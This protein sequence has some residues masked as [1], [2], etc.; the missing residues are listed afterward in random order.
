MSDWVPWYIETFEIE[1]WRSEPT[2][3]TITFYSDVWLSPV[4]YR[5]ARNGMLK[6]WGFSN[7]NNFLLGS[8]IESRHISRRSKLN[9]GALSQFKRQ[10]LFTRMSDWVPWYIEM[11]E[12]ECWSTEQIQT[13]ITF[14]SEVWLSPVIYRGARNWLLKLWPNSNDDNFLL[15]CLIESR[16]ISRC[17]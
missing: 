5:D 13:T 4:I 6:L 2:Q 10:Q 3:T 14:Y 11:L 16:N 7:D 9:V 1:C 8:L 15:G 17:L 12:I